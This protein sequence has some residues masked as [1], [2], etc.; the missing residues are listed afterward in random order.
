MAQVALDPIGRVGCRPL[1]KHRASWPGRSVRRKQRLDLRKLRTLAS[2]RPR[3]R[4]ALALLK[5]SSS[6]SQDKS[7]DQ[8][9]V[10]APSFGGLWAVA[11]A[12]ATLAFAAFASLGFLSKTFAAAR[13]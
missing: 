4:R 12:A 13:R 1:V 10:A 6:P 9:T 11:P 5:L 8:S 3:H 2:A 7:H